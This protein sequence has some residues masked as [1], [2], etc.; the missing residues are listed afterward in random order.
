MLTYHLLETWLSGRKRLTANE[1][2]PNRYHG[3]ESHRLRQNLHLFYGRLLLGSMKKFFQK[4]WWAFLL[5][6]EI[7]KDL[8]TSDSEFD[9]LFREAFRHYVLYKKAEK[10]VLALKYVR[11]CIKERAEARD[12]RSRH[13]KD[14]R[15]AC[16]QIYYKVHMEGKST[17]V[18]ILDQRIHSERGFFSEHTVCLLRGIK[19]LSLKI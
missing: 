11:D 7:S 9:P 14:F 1:V 17:G 18:P 6:I 5:T 19:M 16:D 12:D 2:C 10:R 3:F 4:L 15:W 13:W 8:F